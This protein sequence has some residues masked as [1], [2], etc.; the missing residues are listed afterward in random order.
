MDSNGR[1]QKRISKGTG[2]YATPAWSPRG[3]LIA[4]T[5]NF[6]GQYFLEL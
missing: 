5:K 2:N 4:F 3:D 1:N 6:Q